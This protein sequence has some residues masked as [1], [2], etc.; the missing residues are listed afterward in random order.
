MC[1]CPCGR[2]GDIQYNTNPIIFVC[3]DE[4]RSRM[5]VSLRTVCLCRVYSTSTHQ[6]EHMNNLSK[7]TDFMAVHHN[8]SPQDIANWGRK[9]IRR[10]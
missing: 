8:I 4:A 5:I 3:E 10:K 1:V 2:T 7:Q 9:H 6:Y